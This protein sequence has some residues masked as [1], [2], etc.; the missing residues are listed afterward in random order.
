MAPAE[1][2]SQGG[3]DVTVDEVAV[4]EILR[5]SIADLGQMRDQFRARLY[6]LELAAD[7][8]FLAEVAAIKAQADAGTLGPGLTA[9]EIRERYRL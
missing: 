2:A 1:P 6:A 9:E 7:P 4:A 8:D 3:G 5:A